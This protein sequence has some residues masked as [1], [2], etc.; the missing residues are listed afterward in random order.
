MMKLDEILSQQPLPEAVRSQK[1]RDHTV[2][3]DQVTFRYPRR[4]APRSGPC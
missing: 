2:V 1:P 3:F 4:R